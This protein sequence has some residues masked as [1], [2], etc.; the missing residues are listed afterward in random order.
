M[1]AP[2]A[3]SN[4]TVS[5][6]S[7]SAATSKGVSAP[8]PALS[9]ILAP[10]SRSRRT[11]SFE[12]LKAAQYIA[13]HPGKLVALMF[14]CFFKSSDTISTLLAWTARASGVSWT[15]QLWASMFAPCFSSDSIAFVRRSS[16]AWQSC[17]SRLFWP[18]AG[19]Q[20]ETKLTKRTI[21]DRAFFM[22][23]SSAI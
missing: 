18:A 22:A 8:G 15:S 5:V 13:V 17:A 16:T 12:P 23:F 1:F 20:H 4:C 7:L 21:A 14:A 11:M 2:D 6:L 3:R 9:S 19:R 10:F